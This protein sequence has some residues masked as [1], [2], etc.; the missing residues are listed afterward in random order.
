[1]GTTPQSNQLPDEQFTVNIAIVGGGRACSFFL[2]LLESSAFPLLKINLVGVCDINPEAEG[3]LKAKSMGIF[4]TGDFRDFFAFDNLDSI[5]ELTNRKQVLLELVKLRP[6]R[7]G[8]LEHNIGRFFRDYYM[9]NQ[10][11]QS[12]EHQA[13]M[14]KTAS[15]FIIRHSN[16]AIVV[17]NTDFTIAAAND[18]YLKVVGKTEEEVLGGDCHKIYYNRD[19]PC[20]GS[21][22]MLN[23][24]MLETLQTGQTAHVIHEQR[25]ETGETN[26]GNIVTYPLKDE[27]G[28]ITGV[29][30]IWLDITDD[31]STRWEKRTE[32]LK[33]DLKRMVQEDRMISLGKLVASC[34]HEINNP[35]QG[36]L[37]YCD[38]MRKMTAS[39][40]PSLAN[41]QELDRYLAIVS[42]E[43]VR[44]GDIISGLLSFSRETTPGYVDV[45]LNDI[46]TAATSLTRHKLELQNIELALELAPGLVMVRGD[47]HQLQQAILNLIFNAI[48][49]MPAGGSLAISTHPNAAAQQVTINVKDTGDGIPAD[50]LDHIYDPFFTTKAPGEGTGL[51]LSIVYGIIKNHGGQVKVKSEVNRGTVFSLCL[52]MHTGGL[53]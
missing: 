42:D 1:M 49:A 19:A 45:D 31:L 48:E 30:E 25:T 18:A 34:V 39:K 9:I 29:I 13:A 26:Y 38:L 28:E 2:E 14:A 44:C 53:A 12:A 5:L 3:L 23:C 40:Q 36:L 17:I 15:D 6:R 8:I 20:A 32:D 43:L 4:T 7:V 52:P 50:N 16:A 24:P 22:P 27:H 33:K 21:Q 46:L 51:G 10:R 41:W 35:I 47:T 37:T 11:L